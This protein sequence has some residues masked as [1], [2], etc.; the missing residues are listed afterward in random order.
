MVGDRVGT[1]QHMFS[2]ERVET[3]V[4]LDHAMGRC[5]S[6][7]PADFLGHKLPLTPLKRHLEARAQN[8]GELLDW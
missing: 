4:G 6:I 2:N 5:D 3:F 7:N 1:V 8:K